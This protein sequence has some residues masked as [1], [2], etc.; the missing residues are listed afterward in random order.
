MAERRTHPG[1]GAPPHEWQHPGWTMLSG[2]RPVGSAI[3]RS[4]DPQ[5][6]VTGMDVFDLTAERKRLGLTPNCARCFGLCCVAHGFRASDTFALDK[7]PGKPCP[8][9]LTDFHCTIHRT[10]RRQGF[11]G[12]AA[13]TCY[14]AG[15]RVAQ[16]MFSG[17]DWRQAPQAAEL[18]FQAFPI[19][20]Q[21][22][23][24]LWFITEALDRCPPGADHTELLGLLDATER[25]AA[26]PPDEMSWGDVDHHC[27]AGETVLHQVSA[28][29]RAAAL[30]VEQQAP[31]SRFPPAKVLRLEADR[32]GHHSRCTD[33][34]G[35]DIRG[36]DLRGADLRG[37]DLFGAVLSGAD[38]SGADLRWAD[39]MGADLGRANLA[40]A[41]LSAAIFLTQSQLELADGNARTIL[42]GPLQ[43]PAHWSGAD[44]ES[45]SG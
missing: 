36:A 3:S 26:T 37:A 17:T 7:P 24:L 8:N 10:L 19:V 40:G 21:L 34:H 29:I 1:G 32:R 14:G 45:S 44:G 18:M 38:L 30:S 22:S 43:A 4:E 20:R 35:V 41:D 16:E 28:A 31:A 39:L 42:S 11:S 27:L 33:L 12:C 13:Y 9:L 25:L 15:Q 5:E 2:D 23:Q 6:G